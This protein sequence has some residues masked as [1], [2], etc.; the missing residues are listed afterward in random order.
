MQIPAGLY[1]EQGRSINKGKVYISEC[2][3]AVVSQAYFKQ[4]Q[5]DFSM[6]LG[7]R[8]RELTAGGCMVLILLG[9][10]GPDHVD[11]G[12]SFFWEL[13]SRSLAILVS[14]VPI[15]PY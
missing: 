15:F 6:F 13:L 4:F 8:S 1:D 3:P 9:R 7:S 5:E 2:S 14:Q 11:R 10:I 12:N